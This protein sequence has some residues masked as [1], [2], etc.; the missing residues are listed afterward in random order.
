M[1]N[2]EIPPVQML[3]PVAS[4]TY[5]DKD[6]C[7]IPRRALNRQPLPIRPNVLS[8]FGEELHAITIRSDTVPSAI[9]CSISDGNHSIAS[10][11]CLSVM[12][13]LR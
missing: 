9:C 2:D 5:L 4:A 1:A 12:R 3:P 10:A 13:H 7:T 6:E 11:V 8:G